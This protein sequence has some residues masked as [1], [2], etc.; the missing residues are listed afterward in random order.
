MVL[1]GLLVPQ[2][3][4]VI[5]VQLVPLDQQDLKATQ[6]QLVPQDPQAQTAQCQDL[7]DPLGL[8]AT[9]VALDQLDPQEHKHLL[10]PQDPL[11][12]QVTRAPLDLQDLQDHRVIQ[13]PLDLQDL[14]DLLERKDPQAQLVPVVPQDPRVPPDP[15]ACRATDTL[16]PAPLRWTCPQCPSMMTSHSPWIPV[17]PTQWD[18][19]SSSF[20][21]AHPQTILKPPWSVTQA[22]HSRPTSISS[23]DQAR[24]PTGR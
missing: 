9:Q 13:E 6:D 4:Q 16:H 23:M 11:D 1:L 3:I 17:W 2:A 21:P 24:T 14:Q 18:S 19:L 12:P 8:L 22:A 10:D 7:R 20:Q 15:R 5:L